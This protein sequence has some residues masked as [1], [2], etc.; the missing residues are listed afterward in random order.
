MKSSK[1]LLP[2][3]LLTLFALIA[4]VVTNLTASRNEKV[5][6]D[7]IIYP[8]AR[9]MAQVD[10]YHSVAVKDP[11]RW[12]EDIDSD[13]T[14]AWM[15]AQDE[16]TTKFARQ[17]DDFEHFKS[18]ILEIRSYDRYSRPVRENGRLFFTITPAGTRNALLY[19]QASDAPEPTILIDPEKHFDNDD[20]K[21]RAWTASPNGKF[22]AYTIQ[23]KQSSWRQLKIYDVDSMRDL[24]ETLIGMHRWSGGVQWSRDNAG[25]F[26][27]Q[28]DKPDAES[29]LKAKV[30]NARIKYHRLNHRQA[31]D[32]LVFQRE[33]KPTWLYATRVTLDGRYLIL[34]IADGGSVSNL[35]FYKDLSNSRNEF[36]EL[37]SEANAAYT[38]IGNKESTFWFQTDLNAPSR[39]IIAVD[40]DNPAP[41]NWRELL[42]AAEATLQS[43]KVV[44]DRMIARYVEDAKPLLKVFDIQGR[45]RNRIELPDIGSPGGIA[46]P[47][48]DGNE[49]FYSFNS[50]YDPN[51][52][53]R[54]D[55]KSGES[56]IHYRPKLAF[57]PEEFETEQVFF[58]SKDGTRVPM[59][60]SKKKGVKTHGKAPLFMYGYG[61]WSW[62]AFPWFQP[63][64]LAWMEKGGIYALPGIRGGGEYG[65]AWHQAGIKVNKQN[66]IDDFISAAE[67]LV[68]NDY[69]SKD[70]IVANGGSASGVM[71]GAAL[72]Q[73]P[74]LFGAGIIDIPSLDLI[75]FVESPSGKYLTP[76]YGDPAKPDE[77]KALY[78]FSPYHNLKTGTCYPPTMVMVGERDETAIPMHGYKFIAAL[79]AAQGCDSPALLNV[80]WGAGHNY[81]TTPEQSAE[82]W[83]E[84]LAFLTRVLG[85]AD[86]SGFSKL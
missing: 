46:G 57:N 83:G 38:F 78:S 52:V 24:P 11:Y 71:A 22:V 79:Q 41:K 2:F 69:T 19:M 59:F 58:Q 56:R 63:R 18:R 51:T 35:V 67:W 34:I 64:I 75:R 32:E 29:G 54:L 36:V 7:R 47:Q 80:M 27:N 55:M 49:F 53:Y 82:S 5:N 40:I 3:L 65:E 39:R 43:S 4:F 15:K 70:R 42:P 12:M 72:V 60:I 45:F 17:A 33:D 13:E 44:G 10:D 62:S 6:K 37:I 14:R 68:E 50:L 16:V 31:D 73:R 77:F 48:V 25:F 86:E 28:Y 26:Y 84:A 8:E 66:G 20:L 21:L 81:G 9:R 76:E 74:D 30:E 61:A 1:K 23:D 85:R